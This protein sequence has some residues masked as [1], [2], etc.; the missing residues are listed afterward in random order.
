MPIE[1]KENSQ[2]LIRIINIIN[3]TKSFIS[4][5]LTNIEI[6]KN[7]N[8]FA[9]TNEIFTAEFNKQILPYLENIDIKIFDS[10]EIFN[11]MNILLKCIS[12]SELEIE[13]I[14]NTILLS[15]STDSSESIF[16]SK[17]HIECAFS[18]YEEYNT[19]NETKKEREYMYYSEEKP[20][21]TEE[22]YK[23]FEEGLK[24]FK[25]CPSANRK[26][27]K[28]MGK[29]IH[30]NHVRYERQEMRRNKDFKVKINCNQE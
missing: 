20:R 26:I 22:D 4:Y 16:S 3:V 7:N 21:W 29:H 9:I 11:F 6:I 12:T 10:T 25:D 30:P 15:K 19:S 8:K 13:N 5:I 14:R 17:T 27:A 18:C 1:T 28:Y 24:I 23:K 2:M